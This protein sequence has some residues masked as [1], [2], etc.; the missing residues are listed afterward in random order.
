MHNSIGSGYAGIGTNRCGAVVIDQ[1]HGAM[2]P[3][4]LHAKIA[5]TAGT[6]CRPVVRVGKRDEAMVKLVLDMG[7]A[8]IVFPQV[9][10]AQLATECVATTRSSSRKGA[11]SVLSSGIP[12]GAHPFKIIYPSS[13]TLSSATF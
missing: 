7:A 1:E 13:G 12:G 8:G 11:A 6:N 2:G 5:S 9:N 3:E 4:N 10:T